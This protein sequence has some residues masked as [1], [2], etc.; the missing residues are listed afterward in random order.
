MQRKKKF[1]PYTGKQKSVKRNILQEAQTLDL[2][3]K[4]FK[5]VIIN[6]FKELKKI[7]FKGIRENMKTI[8]HQTKS[9]N[10]E[11]KMYK[12]KPNLDLKSIII[13]NEK[14]TSGIK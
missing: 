11:I 4:D 2:L 7:I 3:N 6:M 13:T 1:V 14:F 9:I 8:S 12:V 10:K 5:S